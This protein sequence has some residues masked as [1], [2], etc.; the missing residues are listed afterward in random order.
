MSGITRLDV[1]TGFLGAGKTTLVARYAAWLKRRGISYC[2]IENE[3][4][5]AGV[6]GA[7][8]SA[9]GADVREI[10]GGCVCC[11]LK[12]TLHDLLRELN[13]K[14]DRIILEPSGL[15]CGDDLLDILHSPDCGVAEGMWVCVLDPPAAAAMSEEDRAVLE[16]ELFAAG[17]VVVSKAQ[18]ADAEELD[19]ARACIAALSPLPAGWT[20]PWDT[21]EDDA[22]FSAMQAAGTVERAHTRR[23]FDHAAMFQSACLSPNGVYSEEELRQVLERSVRP[24]VGAVSRIKGTVAAAQ[25][26][27]RVN[28]TPGCI[29]Y[30]PAAEETQ[31]VLNFIGRGLDRRL[32]RTLWRVGQ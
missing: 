29:G 20:A 17:S 16:S 5:R 28:C 2:I 3:F 32:L 9:D 8:L 4:G 25:G 12:V 6:D 14:V 18:Y 22:W 1:V 26:C 15:F 7:L 23:R 10:S 24:E 31:P 13:G 27:W 19:A 30:S 11:T 21:L